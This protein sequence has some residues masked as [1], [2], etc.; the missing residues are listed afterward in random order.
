MDDDICEEYLRRICEDSRWK[1]EQ[2]SLL[3]FLPRIASLCLGNVT[4]P[5]VLETEF[6]DRR[7]FVQTNKYRGTIH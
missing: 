3:A 7:I 1:W 6:K 5:L 4:A 2:G